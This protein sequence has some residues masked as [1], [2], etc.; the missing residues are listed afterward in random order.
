MIK[1]NVTKLLK[2]L[3]KCEQKTVIES[4]LLEMSILS[5]EQE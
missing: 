5:P 3:K 2:K 1:Q 4:N